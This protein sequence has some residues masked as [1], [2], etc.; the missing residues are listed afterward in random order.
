MGVTGRGLISSPI[1]NSHNS[2]GS[3]SDGTGG[4]KVLVLVDAGSW[5]PDGN[6]LSWE[7]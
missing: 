5:I 7:L 3:S 1:S 6:T 4:D 2:L